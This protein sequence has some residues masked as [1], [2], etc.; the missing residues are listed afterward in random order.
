ML[1]IEPLDQPASGISD[2]L[3]G[4]LPAL[5]S[6]AG[7]EGAPF[8]LLGEVDGG[9]LALVA[10]NGASLR[11]GARG[12]GR[13]AFHEGAPAF[14]DPRL[15]PGFDGAKRLP[16]PDGAR[17]TAEGDDR[18]AEVVVVDAGIAFWNPAFGRR[19]ASVG[20]IRPDGPGRLLLDALDRSEIDA[21][22][23]RGATTLGDVRNREQLARRFPGSVF[24]ARDGHPPLVRR[25]HLAHG[26]AMAD[27]VAR[28]I[29]PEARLHGVE[30]P[31]SVL[32]DPTGG[33][34]RGLLDVALRGAVL[35]AARHRP[36]PE[37]LRVVVLMAYGFPGGPQDGAAPPDVLARLSRSL[38]AF[39]GRGIA[40]EVVLPMGNH[41]QD[42]AHARL[43]ETEGRDAPW[44][45]WRILPDDHS[46]NVVELIHDRGVPAL[47]VAAPDGSV[48]VRREGWPLALLF[49]GRGPI[50]AI[51]TEPLSDGRGRT[52]VALAPTAG[53]DTAIP[54]APFGRWR[55]RLDAGGAAQAWVL[56]DDAGF[57]DD[58]AAPYRRSWFEDRAYRPRDAI[59]MP[60]LDDALHPA[61]AVRR[62][63]S[64]SLLALSA[65][66]A[67]E[68]VAASWDGPA[69]SPVG[70]SYSGL[71]APGHGRAPTP[72]VVEAPGPFRGLA[73]LGN[74]SA[75]V[76]R[77]SGTSVAA[78]LRAGALSHP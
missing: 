78:A 42:R 73:A 53:R 16:L 49:G 32:R 20:A 48:A 3:P 39:A 9:D 21:M 64:A 1:A 35:L 18:P 29:H 76:F 11:R 5:L 71:F 8:S 70:A 74:G 40:V 37:P 47:C 46:A 51:L 2:L 24:A 77:V 33:A 15:G 68:P 10:V 19:F 4:A 63:G 6:G 34:L 13:A 23:L 38:A 52:R 12:E 58:R 56:R 30:L 31:V 45:D 44:L 43:P 36:P 27:L 50:G 17:E 7:R 25:E 62:E 65:E 67:V 66:P 54:R 59:G 75:R 41:L 72:V 28:T 22:V 60:G 57:D 69:A 26:T 14:L 55:L 61:S